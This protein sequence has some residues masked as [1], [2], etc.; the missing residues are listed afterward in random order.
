MRNSILFLGLAGLFLGW[1]LP[2]HYPLWTTFHGELASALGAC[3]L[4]FGTCMPIGHSAKEAGLDEAKRS[5]PCQR[6]PMPRAVVAW[7]ALALLPPVQYAFGQL[8]FY[9]DGVLGLLYAMGVA[10]CIYIGYLWA[11]QVGVAIVLKSLYLTLVWAGLAAGGLA[12]AQWMQLPASGWWAMELID[13]RPF[14]NLAQ[15]NLFGLLM[16]LGMIAATAL[17]EMQSIGHRHSYY[18]LMFFFAWAMVICQSRASLLAFSLVAVLWPL[19]HRRVTSRL[20]WYEVVIGV[21]VVWSLTALQPRIDDTLLLASGNARSVLEVGPRGAIWLHFMTAIRLHPWFGYGFG[22]GV[23]ALREAAAQVQPSRNTIY[24]HNLVLDLITWFGLPL[25]LA[26]TGTLGA[27]MLGWLRKTTDAKLMAQRHVVFAVWLALLVQSLL[28]YPYA[29]AFFL[30]PAALLAGAVTST[31]KG[32]FR[33]HLNR[34]ACATPSAAALGVF[35]ATLLSAVAWD[36]LQFE[37]EFRANRFDRGNVGG[38]ATHEAQVG[39]V[40][41]DQLAALNASA[42]LAPRPGMPT[43]ELALLGK[44]ARRFHMLPTRMDYAR[45]LALNGRINEAQSE[46]QMVRAVSPPAQWA[47]IDREWLGWRQQN[48]RA[49]S[50][51]R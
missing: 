7:L 15:P 17:Y 3:F 36:Y 19:T 20:H 37:A 47:R 42:H 44:V 32:S 40:I 25:G 8:D 41:L 10:M 21:A 49:I 1:N 39:P 26:M 28:E 12:L 46:L 50:P 34:R 16:V 14:A 23:L 35:A 22:Q 18:L 33:L 13:A 5:Q 9:G 43:S 29:H 24:A 31:A 11:A 51:A 48:Q 6:L 27:W 45:A 38:P 30:L 4:F 2:N